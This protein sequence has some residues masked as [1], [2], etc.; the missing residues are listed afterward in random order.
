MLKKSRK[1]S[2]ILASICADTIFIALILFEQPKLEGS[3]QIGFLILSGVILLVIATATFYSIVVRMDERYY[4]PGGVVGWAM[5][6]I[7]TAV[8]IGFGQR[9]WPDP[10]GLAVVAVSAF[11]FFQFLVFR[12][13]WWIQTLLKRPS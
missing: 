6:G 12:A 2:I 11:L 4:G 3:D 13:V 9:L 1:S 10:L 5:T 8:T 7:F